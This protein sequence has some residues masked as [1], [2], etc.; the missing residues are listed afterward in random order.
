MCLIDAEDKMVH[1]WTWAGSGVIPDNI[2]CDC[3]EV[4]FGSNLFINEGV[5]C[6]KID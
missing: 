3:Q 5:L 6:L 4:E 1:T 2:L